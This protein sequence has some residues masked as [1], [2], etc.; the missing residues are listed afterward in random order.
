MTLEE[1]LQVAEALDE[2]GM[3]IIEAGFPI[4]SN[5]DFEAVVAV[6]TQVKRATIAGLTRAITAD[7][8]RASE[9]IR[10][11]QKGRI[12]IFVSTSPIHLVHR[13]ACPQ[14]DR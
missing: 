2:I 14:S 3:D 9:A 7:I 5:G 12:H 1:K 4:A 13:G 8:D 6:A 10:F 11:P